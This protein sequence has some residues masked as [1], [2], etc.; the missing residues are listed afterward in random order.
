MLTSE[1]LNQVFYGDDKM[2]RVEILAEASRLT[3]GERNKEYGEPKDNL[4][5]CALLWEAYIR[6]KYIKE[7]Q[8]SKLILSRSFELS[9]EDVAWLNVLQKIARTFRGPHKPDTY[10]DAA[11]YAAIAGEISE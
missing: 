8:S 4:G 7:V 11:A 3:G 2:N 1:F 6:A 5:D 10:I 9:A